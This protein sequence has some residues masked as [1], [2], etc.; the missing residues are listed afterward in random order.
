[1]RWTS[2]IF[3]PK[4]A[5]FSQFSVQTFKFITF[6]SFLSSDIIPTSS[7]GKG[8]RRIIVYWFGHSL[9]SANQ[10][11]AQGIKK[12]RKK[13]GWKETF[14]Y[15]ILYYIILYYIILYLLQLIYF[16][17]VAFSLP[18][19]SLFVRSKRFACSGTIKRA[20]SGHQLAGLA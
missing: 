9:W 3:S 14:C 8:K 16:S 10:L 17:I 18:S 11:P 19:Q 4:I 20:T 1:M 7:K 15:P 6:W 12:K 2:R 13:N 5:M